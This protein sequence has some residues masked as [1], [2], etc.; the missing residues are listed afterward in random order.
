[1]PSAR[2][3]VHKMMPLNGRAE[4]KETPVTAMV[5][6]LQC[7]KFT[8]HLMLIII[9]HSSLL[10][11]LGFFPFL[12]STNHQWRTREA[13]SEHALP[14]Q[15]EVFCL[16]MPKLHRRCHPDLCHHR[17]P[18]QKSRRAAPAHRCLSRATPS[19]RPR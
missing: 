4:V 17:G 7:Y 6:H 8:L 12:S 11:A 3:M 18:H 2:C 13:S 1:M 10:L 16:M 19:G 5:W 15:R 9:S 14:S